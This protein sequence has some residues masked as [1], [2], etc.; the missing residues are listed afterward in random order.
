MYLDAGETAA[1]E[2]VRA[3]VG[4]RGGEGGRDGGDDRWMILIR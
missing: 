3:S 1:G 4:G 2:V